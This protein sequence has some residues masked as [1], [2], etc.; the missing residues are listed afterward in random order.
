MAV[1]NKFQFTSNGGP[2]IALQIENEFGSYGNTANQNDA[3]YLKALENFVRKSGFNE[4][5]F[6]SDPGATK[7]GTLPGFYGF[8]AFL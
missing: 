4:L 1:V 8:L 2:V 5:L 3:E 6:T 7:Q